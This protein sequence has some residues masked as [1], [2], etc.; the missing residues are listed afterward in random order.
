MKLL[1]LGGTTFVGRGVVEAALARG[2]AVTLF[3]RG[4]TAPNLFPDVEKLRGDRRGDLGA[5]KGRRFDVAVDTSGFLPSEVRAA[6]RAITVE[7]YLFVSTTMAYRDRSRAGMAEGDPVALLDEE[8]LQALE[9]DPPSYDGAALSTY[10]HYGALKAHCEVALEG[11]L[12]GRALVV[13]PGVLVGPRDPFRRLA[14]WTRRFSDGGDVLAPGRPER[15][16]QILDVRDHAAWVIT[17]AERGERGCFNASGAPLSACDVLEECRRGCDD[18]RLTWVS[19]E[20]LL[21]RG[22]RPFF[23]LPLYIP[24]RDGSSWGVF[25][26]DNRKAL[27]SG[28]SHRPI[29]ETIRDVRATDGAGPA[30]MDRA[31]EAELIAEWR[32]Q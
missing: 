6:A 28:L 1:V 24:E 9:R 31:R 7:R 29:A 21:S 15:R 32:S 13:R 2:H 20:F 3:N 30:G 8:R 17:L 14:Y 10:Q 4:R 5:L 23:E 27:A 26:M 19:D 22:V 12:P 25:A 18:A 16:V 11:E